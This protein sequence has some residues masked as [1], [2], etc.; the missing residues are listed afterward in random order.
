LCIETGLQILFCGGLFWFRLIKV[1][2][3][4]T[5]HE[6][7]IERRVIELFLARFLPCDSGS[8]YF[9]AAKLLM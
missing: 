8:K 7:S 5:S 9:G 2:I 3:L 1:L 4:P 6:D